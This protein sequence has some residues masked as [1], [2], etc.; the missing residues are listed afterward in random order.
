MTVGKVRMWFDPRWEEPGPALLGRFRR[1]AVGQGWTDEEVD[2]VML[3][4]AV[5]TS[6][7]ALVRELQF[8]VI[9]TPTDPPNEPEDR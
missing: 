8:W 4:P 3:D 5:L 7:D 1:R 2:R 6:Y 9:P